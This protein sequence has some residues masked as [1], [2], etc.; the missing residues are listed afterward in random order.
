[1]PTHYGL[2]EKCH[3]PVVEPQVPAYP[4]T[5]WE[6]LRKQGGANVIHLRERIPNRVRHQKCLPK[7]NDE[8]GALL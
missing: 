4:V 2:C 3:E 8:Q 5:G 6:L 7:T 1:M